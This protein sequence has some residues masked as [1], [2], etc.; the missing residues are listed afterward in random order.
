[1]TPAMTHPHA[2]AMRARD[3]NATQPLLCHYYSATRPLLR[4][5]KTTTGCPTWIKPRTFEANP[6]LSEGEPQ[7]NSKVSQTM[8]S[9]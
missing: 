2:R 6:S 5:H 3:E 8:A 4:H 1:M 9:T 7:G